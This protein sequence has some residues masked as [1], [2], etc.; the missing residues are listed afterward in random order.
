MDLARW[1]KLGGRILY[2]YTTQLSS[3][4]SD[5]Q[6]TI[7]RQAPFALFVKL[8]G[9]VRMSLRRLWNR[10]GFT[11][12]FNRR[13]RPARIVMVVSSP[14]TARNSPFW[15]PAKMGRGGWEEFRL[16]CS[17]NQP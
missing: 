14:S 9:G 4:N 5:A 6:V 7:Q 11:A 13:F 16:V 15:L 1:T 10:A 8:T 3:H 12:D 2:H 17:S